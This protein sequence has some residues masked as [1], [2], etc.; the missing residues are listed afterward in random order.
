MEKVVSGKSGL[1]FVVGSNMGLKTIA[2][3]IYRRLREVCMTSGAKKILQFGAVIG[4]RSPWTRN[5]NCVIVNKCELSLC[6]FTVLTKRIFNPPSCVA[7]RWQMAMICGQKINLPSY[8]ARQL[9]MIC[10]KKTDSSS[11]VAR[12]MTMICGQKT[13]LLSC[14]AR[15][16][17]MICGQKT[18][19][20][21]CI[22]RKTAIICGRKTKLSLRS[23]VELCEKSNVSILV[24]QRPLYH[25]CGKF[26]TASHTE[27][28]FKASMKTFCFDYGKK[29]TLCGTNC[30]KVRGLKRAIVCPELK[31]SGLL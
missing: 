9:A 6:N 20:P 19:S 28:S 15:K 23:C 2:I 8:V 13:N 30:K 7:W 17:S 27:L 11:C 31:G 26:I 22:A 1:F 10:G 25:I 24:S 18:N 21:S 12:Q 4:T 5:N 29:F 16:M 3:N 14:V